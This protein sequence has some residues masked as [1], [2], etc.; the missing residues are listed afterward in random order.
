MKI[1]DKEKSLIRWALCLGLLAMVIIY[2]VRAEGVTG[3]WTE[4]DEKRPDVITIDSMKVF[5]NLERPAV[6]F[7]HDR[8]TEALSARGQDCS[9]CHLKETDS[10]GQ[11]RL[12]IKYKRI[13]DTTRNEVMSI[14][15]TNC[16]QCHTDVASEGEKSG[17]LSCG[18]CHREKPGVISSGQPM[19]MDKS[20]HFRHVKAHEN[21]CE[22]CHHEYDDKSKTLFY[23]KGR[24]G[25]CRYCHMEETQENRISMR[26]ASHISCVD[27]HLKTKAK[28]LASGPVD[29]QG[30]HD[31]S[32]RDKIEVVEDIPRMERGQPDIVFVN[33]E[34]PDPYTDPEFKKETDENLMNQV[35]F[36][37]LS[38]ENY[39]DT[40]RVCHHAGMDSCVTCHSLKGSKEGN[41]VRLETSMHKIDS[42]T[43]CL[44]C[45]ENSKADKNCAG[46]HAFMPAGMKKKDPS[47][48][49]SCHMEPFPDY[50]E[51]SM[52]ASMTA[53]EA[54]N[55]VIE[56]GSVHKSDPVAE[57]L[58]E[59]RTPI[60]ATYDEED[61][62]EKVIIKKLSKQYEPTEL[63]H[64]KIVNTLMKNIQ[65]S[66]ITQYFHQDPGTLCQGCHHNSPVS[67]K[68]P[69]CAS[70]H[71]EGLEGGYPYKPGLMA[72]YHNQ[73]MGCHDQMG[74]E[75][76]A[77]ND[78]TAC[79]KEK[80]K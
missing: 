17:P 32:A 57:M 2:G 64:R 40:C 9:A 5:G 62:P 77:K 59:S 74:I 3:P 14:Y 10:R 1:L 52:T 78:C 25:T 22:Q 44:G 65:D 46:C 29:C 54:S 24:E 45:H 21:K 18:E 12:S 15:H 33:R 6:I 76:P 51:P 38:H 39:N 7:L 79:H 19:G 23:A 31:L 50:L 42:D 13:Q 43:S 58:L 56:N 60:A 4:P 73:C 53:T 16:L 36:S 66:K 34:Q 63:P 80:K 72:A 28:D 30:C 71:G 49:V 20:L 61:I 75:K 8:H 55:E 48:C 41:F 11:E 37:H 35:P 69:S 26:E 27:C 67:K 47:S 70:C 68:P